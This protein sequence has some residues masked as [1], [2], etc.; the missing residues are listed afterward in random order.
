MTAPIFIAGFGLKSTVCP[1]L[2]SNKSF[3]LVVETVRVD[4]SAVIFRQRNSGWKELA[5][6]LEL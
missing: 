1:T 5:S 3:D 6:G 4:S 2:G